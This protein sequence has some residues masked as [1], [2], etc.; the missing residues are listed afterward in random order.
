MRKP[1]RSIPFALEGRRQLQASEALPEGAPRR[2]LR[3]EAAAIFR[4][5][6]DEA[7]D[8]DEAPE[9]AWRAAELYAELGE[10]A[11]A[12]EMYRRS[13]DRYA[14]EAR[15]RA[16]DV[17]KAYAALAMLH[18]RLGDY[19]AQARVLVEESEQKR[20]PAQVRGAAAR[21][22]RELR[23]DRDGRGL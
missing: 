2:A 19:R 22:A 20:L 9:A 8:R 6:V 7:P 23:R 5:F 3:R 12:V 18:A 21:Q 15:V 17:E 16:A 11:R 1:V 10:H 13:I 4:Q 14:A